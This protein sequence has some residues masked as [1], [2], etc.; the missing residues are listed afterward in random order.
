[1]NEV[2]M[3]QDPVARDLARS[4]VSR[5]IRLVS[6]ERDDI[7]TKYFYYVY[8]RAAPLIVKNC[9]WFKHP[10]NLIPEWQRFSYV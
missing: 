6:W 7:L 3:W 8:I 5:E 9:A 4:D 1:M 10:R 2:G